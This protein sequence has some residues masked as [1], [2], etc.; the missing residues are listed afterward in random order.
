M[1]QRLWSLEGLCILLRFFLRIMFTKVQEVDG[2]VVNI[3]DLLSTTSLNQ[4]GN[5]LDHVSS[6]YFGCWLNSVLFVSALIKLPAS[7]RSICA[8]KLIFSS[9]P[10]NRSG[11]RRRASLWGHW[12][13]TEEALPAF[14]IEIVLWSVG[15]PIIRS[16]MSS[17]CTKKGRK[18]DRKLAF[19]IIHLHHPII[20]QYVRQPIVGH[21]HIRRLYC[22][23][24]S[25]QLGCRD[26]SWLQCSMLLG[27]GDGA[28]ILELSS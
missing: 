18:T 19:W 23:E 12:M 22:F 27:L 20:V 28:V 10:T 17:N 21:I 14:S 11:T 2:F 5:E 25:Y 1:C 24:W 26:W 15:L 4:N 3:S 9:S 13:V 16:G 7:I 8:H 6:L